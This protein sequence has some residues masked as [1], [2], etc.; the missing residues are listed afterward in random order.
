MLR[1]D[2][3]RTSPAALPPPFP[4]DVKDKVNAKLTDLKTAIGN[5]DTA[6]MKTAMEA[7]QVRSGRF[8]NAEFL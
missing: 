8:L 3:N 6:G 4:Q 5:D 2:G 1:S 7:L